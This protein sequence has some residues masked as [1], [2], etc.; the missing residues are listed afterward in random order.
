MIVIVLIDEAG[1]IQQYQE[2]EDSLHAVLT[3]IKRHDI[4][5][6]VI[7]EMSADG[8]EWE[9]QYNEVSIIPAGFGATVST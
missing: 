8:V 3:A 7:G 2:N 1:K 5:K 4:S 6:I 9:K